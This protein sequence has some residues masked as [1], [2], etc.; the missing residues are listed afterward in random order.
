MKTT[1]RYIMRA[2]ALSCLFAAAA[3]AYGGEIRY[4]L[5]LD[6]SAIE[7]DTINAPDGTPYLR[8][9]APDCDYVGEPGAPMIPY[10]CI[11]FLVPTYSNNFTVTVDNVTVAENRTL[12][13]PLYPV[14]EPQLHNEI[15]LNEF[16]SF[17][18]ESYLK[19]K[20]CPSVINEYFVN[21]DSH[22]VQVAMPV[23]NYQPNN[24]GMYL[25][26]S[27]EFTL[28]YSECQAE[29]MSLKPISCPNSILDRDLAELVVNPP[30]SFLS[31]ENVQKVPASEIQKY[32]YIL[33]PES[34]KGSLSNLVSWKRQR[35]YNV[36]LKT[37]EEIL[38]DHTY[39]VYDNE[40]AFDKESHVKNW[41]KSEYS[42]TGAFNLL[43]IGN[44]KTNA[45]I[46]KFRLSRSSDKPIDNW[47]DGP[48]VFPSDTYFS[49]MS[50]PYEL[51][52]Y[53][54]YDSGKPDESYYSQY[55][56]DIESYSP[57]LPTGRLLVKDPLEIN[58]Y[59]DKLLIYQ[60]D[61]GLG[62][63][64][65]LNSAVLCKQHDYVYLKDKS[66]VDAVEGIDNKILHIDSIGSTNYYE[67][68]PTGKEVIDEMRTSGLTSLQGHGSARSIEVA[69]EHHKDWKQS[70][71]LKPLKSSPV[72]EWWGNEGFF[73][74]GNS[75]EDLANYGKPS[76]LYTGACSSAPFG[77]IRFDDGYA[78]TDYSM[79]TAFLF[80]GNFG[81][82]AYIATS[83]DASIWDNA[84]EEDYFG[85]RIN[86]NPNLARAIVESDNPSKKT[87]T[88]F[89][90]NLIGDPDIDL[91]IGSPLS[92]SLRAELNYNSGGII[93]SGSHLGNS[94]IVL[95]DGVETADTYTTNLATTSVSLTNNMS[96]VISKGDFVLSLY[97]RNQLPY[98][99][100]FA[101]SSIIKNSSKNYFLREQ[102]LSDSKEN[103]SPC[104]ILSDNGNLN[105]TFTRGVET[106][107]AFDIRENGKVSVSSFGYAKF[108]DDV[109]EAGGS[110]DVKCKDIEFGPGFCVNKGGILT[111]EVK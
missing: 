24:K 59:F 73:E 21:G 94:T 107:K 35:G 50:T 33:T 31:Y 106:K 20:N 84:Y 77:E 76:V 34:L 99:K 18:N 45:P 53:E 82:V 92:T 65:Y 111:V 12:G 71:Y 25:Y 86:I 32:Y 46:R 100:L 62:D 75:F 80:A 67:T 66:I 28:N 38:A 39:D 7:T 68:F 52:K 102:I 22:I 36:I 83:R 81:G 9:W 109:V 15:F 23:V 37:V 64:S 89:M 79:C 51:I 4:T 49:D 90:R 78:T 26:E 58:R 105:L 97:H 41:L 63:S 44:D 98:V 30:M 61:P 2:V 95:Y 103:G 57:V 87:P 74:D 19:F 55:Y 40:R 27:L 29:E 1:I 14:Q 48:H 88:K 72:K 17:E 43:L 96:E 108:N 42:K 91:W 13:L 6:P 54:N 16:I 8:L 85:K 60:L 104:Y 11:N 70:R 93:I 10:K 101:S 47:P 69:G 3:T 5:R 56:Y 110:L